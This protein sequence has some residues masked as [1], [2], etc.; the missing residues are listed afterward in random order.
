MSEQQEMGQQSQ[1]SSRAIHVPSVK[2]RPECPAFSNDQLGS[3][4]NPPT[5]LRRYLN[6]TVGMRLQLI[7][8]GQYPNV[9]NDQE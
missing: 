6:I 5:P 3:R 2:K 4:V 7:R 1:T 9:I 8:L